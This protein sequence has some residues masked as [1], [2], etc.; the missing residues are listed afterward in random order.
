MTYNIP[1]KKLKSW[2]KEEKQSS[3]EYRRYGLNSISNDEMR[4]SKK[5][6]KMYKKQCV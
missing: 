6:S 3:K 1:C 4:H 5:L 2:S